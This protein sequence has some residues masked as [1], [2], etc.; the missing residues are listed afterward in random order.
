VQL[1][2][3]RER[4]AR[5]AAEASR[6]AAAAAR[7]SEQEIQRLRGEVCRGLICCRARV[8]FV[9]SCCLAPDVWRLT[10]GA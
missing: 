2:A 1:N 8:S 6:T 7:A 9:S 5:A 4:A 10:F 3:E